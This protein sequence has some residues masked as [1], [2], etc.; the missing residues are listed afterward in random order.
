[1]IEACRT[2]DPRESEPI[3]FEGV[4]LT[5]IVAGFDPHSFVSHERI[6]AR[7]PILQVIEGL[8]PGRFIELSGDQ[9]VL[10]RHPDC[11]IVLDHASVSRQHAEIS[12]K[13]DQYFISDL[14]SRNGTFVNDHAVNESTRL[15]HGDS[16]VICDIRLMF[17]ENIRFVRSGNDSGDEFENDPSEETLG[18]EGALLSGKLDS[19]S[20]IHTMDANRSSSFHYDVRPEIKLRAILEITTAIGSELDLDKLLP[21]VMDSLFSLF[22]QTDTGLF[23]LAEQSSQGT[24][25]RIKAT[26]QR[27]ANR[28]RDEVQISQTIIQRAMS[29]GEALLTSDV[30]GDTRFQ[31]SQSLS[32]LEIQSMMCVPLMNQ[33]SQALGVIQLGTNNMANRF[34][35]ENLD[36]LVSVGAS[37][38]VA[39]D[40]AFLHDQIVHQHDLQRDLEFATQIQKSFLPQ[41][42]PQIK[43][44]QFFD[45]YKAA[46]SVGGDYYDYIPLPDGRIGITLG[47]VSGKGVAAALLMARIGTATRFHLA[48]H[49]SPSDALSAINAELLQ[50]QFGYRFITFIILLLDPNTHELVVSNAG[51]MS[52][53]CRRRDGTVERVTGEE[54]GVPLGV[55]RSADYEDSFYHLDAGDSITLFTDGITEAMNPRRELFGM[56]RLN[57]VLARC[58]G[59]SATIVDAIISEVSRFSDQKAAKDDSCIVV[60]QRQEAQGLDDTADDLNGD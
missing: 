36:L 13:D 57:D 39:I 58:A 11:E 25:L 54:A 6:G 32:D 23:V 22:P 24:Q 19:S 4:G 21:K 47:D 3:D 26:K 15:E 14:K 9:M 49:S 41:R 12:K 60:F 7:V 35:E 42:R 30:K 40:N 44:Y 46:R 50:E 55:S 10:G 48:A 34:S 38:A 51:H 16:I 37:V 2:F 59:N 53:F 17:Q 31:G 8:T 33:D 27:H 56:D 5:G 43:H 28:S 45:Y 52:P 18:T 1:M 20:I 29:S